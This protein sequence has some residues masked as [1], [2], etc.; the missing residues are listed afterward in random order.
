M[1]YDVPSQADIYIRVRE[2]QLQVDKLEKELTAKVTRLEN[3]IKELKWKKTT[4]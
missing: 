1:V 3:K 4:N 2:L